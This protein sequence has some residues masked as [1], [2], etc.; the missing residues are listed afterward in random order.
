MIVKL[1]KEKNKFI[2]KQ[3]LIMKKI[4]KELYNNKFKYKNLSF[5]KSHNHYVFNLYANVKESYQLMMKYLI[6]LR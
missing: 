6:K 3:N 1:C 4:K 2:V 5:L